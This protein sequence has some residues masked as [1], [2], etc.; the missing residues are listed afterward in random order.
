MI[1]Y[2]QVNFEF[3]ALSLYPILYL[4]FVTDTVK[5]SYE[6]ISIDSWERERVEGYTVYNVPLICGRY[7]EKFDCYR[8]LGDDTW[9]DWFERYFIGGRRRIQMN[10][11]YALTSD[12]QRVLNRYGNCTQSTGQ[13][14]ISRNVVVQRNIDDIDRHDCD[15]KGNKQKRQKLPT[16][17]SVLLSYHRARKKLEYFAE[18]K[19]V[20][21]I[22]EIGTDLMK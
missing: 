16:I 21:S 15:I 17:S 20:S 3:I 19:E 22:R 12:D 14:K 13:L 1:A 4:F 8:D 9:R 18:N 5:I 10:D 7:I 11:F 2:S 6:I